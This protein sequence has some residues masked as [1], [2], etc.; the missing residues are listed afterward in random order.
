MNST[1]LFTFFA[2]AGFTVL[3]RLP[4]V[5]WD[6]SC[7]T[8]ECSLFIIAHFSGMKRS[9]NV[10]HL[11]QSNG[12]DFSLLFAGALESNLVAQKLPLSL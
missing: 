9:V 8:T 5:L 10:A 4:P 11:I 12:N 7:L 3:V 6:F 1:P 2:R